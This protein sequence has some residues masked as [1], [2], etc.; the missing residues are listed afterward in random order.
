[1]HPD[2]ENRL[3]VVL[4]FSRFYLK[5]ALVLSRFSV[6]LKQQIYDLLSI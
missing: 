4:D 5:H 3:T 1:M 6:S 2:S